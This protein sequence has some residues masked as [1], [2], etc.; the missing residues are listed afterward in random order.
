MVWDEGDAIHRAAGIT[1]GDW[2]YTNVREGHPAFY[3]I[4]IAAGE[5]IVPESWLAPLTR[6]RLG[7]ILFYAVAVGFVFWRVEKNYGR[8][9]AAAAAVALVTIPR[10]FAHA[11][12][13]TCDGTLTAAWL[14]TWA[15]ASGWFSQEKPTHRTGCWREIGTAAAL[16]LPLGMT[17][18]AKATGWLAPVPLVLCFFLRPSWRLLW[19]LSSAAALTLVVFVLLNPSIWGNPMGGLAEF[20]TLNSTRAENA[21]SQLNITT[22]F[23]GRFYNLG[24]ELG[25]GTPLPWWNAFFWTMITVPVL[26]FFA[27]LLGIFTSMR[28]REGW[29]LLFSW[30]VLLVVRA[31]P[32]VPSH[33]GVRLFLPSIAF[34]AILAGIGAETFRKILGNAVNFLLGKSSRRS[35]LLVNACVVILVL[36][37]FA[38]L[39]AYRHCPLSYYN[40]MI[41]G[42]PGATRVGM[43]PTYFWDACGEE[44]LTWLRENTEP[45]ERILFAG[46]IP[47]NNRLRR[48]WGELPSHNEDSQPKWYVVQNRTAFLR[49]WEYKLFAMQQPAYV[50]SHRGVWLIAVYEVPSRE[51]TPRSASALSPQLSRSGHAAL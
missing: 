47:H 19:M 44:V 27:A 51:T 14:I 42:L 32:G 26:W 45:D 6:W 11:H 4:T 37:N 24:G 8:F 49:P 5:M 16:A 17:L 3:G 23:L 39:Y 18:A 25:T 46:A 35:A 31:F 28:S 50:L 29:L 10:L 22:C 20:I 30:V 12:F 38:P 41:G 7:P 9:A 40:G 2:E 13:A 34:F 43:E 21:T 15:I 33:D 1:Q 36:A 48:S